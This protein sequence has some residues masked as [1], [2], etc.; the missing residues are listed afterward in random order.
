MSEDAKI[1]NTDNTE[2]LREKSETG[3]IME[4]ENSLQ[5]EKIIVIVECIVIT[6]AQG[7]S[8][9][10]PF[11]LL[12]RRNIYIFVRWCLECENPKWL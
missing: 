7:L 1:K 8:F 4:G 10:L 5:V 2:D 12:R 3:K 6:S 9:F 11:L